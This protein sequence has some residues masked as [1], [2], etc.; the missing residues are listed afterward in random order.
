MESTLQQYKNEN[1]K[2]S[3]TLTNDWIARLS[4]VVDLNRQSSRAAQIRV[5]IE[6]SEEEHGI[7]KDK[8]K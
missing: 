1:K 4:K 8:K 6:D 3:I 5:W 2:S 7:S